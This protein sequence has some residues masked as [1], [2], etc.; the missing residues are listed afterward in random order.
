MD[1]PMIEKAASDKN[2]SVFDRNFR[3]EVYMSEIKNYQM[4]EKTFDKDGTIII[5]IEKFTDE[6][7]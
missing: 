3:M 7:Q 6:Q 1:K 5:P 2:C 4:E